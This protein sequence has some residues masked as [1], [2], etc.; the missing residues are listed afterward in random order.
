MGRRFYRWLWKLGAFI[1]IIRWIEKGGIGEMI[2]LFSTFD[3]IVLLFIF[4]TLL[5]GA[6]NT[7]IKVISFLFVLFIIK[8][9]IQDIIVGYFVQRNSLHLIIWYFSV[10]LI[11]AIL[12]FYTL[13]HYS[14]SYS[15]AV[16][17]SFFGEMFDFIIFI[18]VGGGLYLSGE[19]TSLLH[20]FNKKDLSGN[21]KI[22]YCIGDL[23]LLIILALFCWIA[24]K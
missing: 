16:G 5:A 21:S 10:D 2:F 18:L 24:K 9:F 20:G 13:K 7:L 3:I 19:I 23:L 6:I 15:Q 8:D 1:K 12:F 17:L 4:I 14:L 22:F 11:R